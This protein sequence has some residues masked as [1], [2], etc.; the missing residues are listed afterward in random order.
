MKESESLASLALLL[1]VPAVGFSVFALTQN[2]TV[3]VILEEPDVR[4]A[5][6]DVAEP[7]EKA[8][9][10]TVAATFGTLK[11]HRGPNGLTAA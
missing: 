10:V 2:P 1:A 7:L 4:D 6:R 3:R 5:W 11:R 8:L 9:R